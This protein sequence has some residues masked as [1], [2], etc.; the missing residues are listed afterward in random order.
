[1]GRGSNWI[2][3]RP[4]LGRD[5]RRAGKEAEYTRAGRERGDRR[6]DGEKQEDG[7]EMGKLRVRWALF[8]NVPQ[9]VFECLLDARHW[10]GAGSV[11]VKLTL[12]LLH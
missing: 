9:A 5:G 8:S 3:G 4:S 1:M 6:G 10:V 11:R 2:G 7:A 12:G